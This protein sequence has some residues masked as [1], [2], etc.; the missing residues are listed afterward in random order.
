MK[1]LNNPS[2]AT[3]HEN[4]HEEKINL[5]EI[6]EKYLRHWKWFI[7]SVVVSLTLA[8]IFLQYATATYQSKAL[9]LIKEDKDAK[10][11]MDFSV[12][13]DLGLSENK[14]NL[15]NEIAII[16][17]RGLIETVS[18]KLELNK[19]IRGSQDDYQKHELYKNAPIRIES[20]DSDSLLEEKYSFE[21]RVLDEQH[22]ELDG[23][24]L[25]PEKTAFGEV[26]KTS[27]GPL[28]V[29]KTAFFS[30]KWLGEVL[31]I[32]L[33]PM[34]SVVSKLQKELGV[35]A[36]NKDADVL[37][38]KLTGPVIEKTNHIINELI[39]QYNEDAIEDKNEIARN[40]S[41]F[42]N[43]RMKVITV[44]LS[45]VEE[46]GESF[47]SKHQLV[48][49]TSDAAMYLTKESEVEKAITEATIQLRLANYM[50]DYILEHPGT[51][52]LLPANLGFENE[53]VA[54]M[55]EEYNK[56]VL[57]R[58]RILQSSGEKNPVILR[59]D[60]Q[61]EGMKQSLV[62]SLKNAEHTLE[63]NLKT[64]RGQE[65]IYKSQIASIPEYERE[66]R[67]ILRQQQIKETLYIYL[68]QKREENEIALASTV[69]NAKVIDFAYSNGIPVFPRKSIILVIALFV[70]L[71]IPIAVIYVRDLLDY[72]VHSIEDLQDL[73][74]P[75]VGEIPFATEK[76]GPI[77]SR[78]NNSVI[79]EAFRLVRTNI[80]FMLDRKK[81]ESKIIFITSG[82]SGE[83]KTF[84]SLNLGNIFANTGK[85]TVVIGLD[86]RAPKIQQY[87]NYPSH[88][89]VSNFIV[90]EELSI[91]DLIIRD[92]K[93]ENLD[94]IFS[95]DV[96]P[97]PSELLMRDRLNEL[98]TGLRTRYDY[99]IVDTAP[100]GLVA[101]TLHTGVYAD[102][103]LYVIRANY[104]DKRMLT[105]P[106]DLYHSG[107]LP[108][109]AVVL[110][111]V[112][113][114]ARSYGYGYGY[115]AEAVASK[116]GLFRKVKK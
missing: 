1:D 26:V 76:N 67:S 91:D 113:L 71:L 66:Y 64:L 11:L 72:K 58:N 10:S 102:L 41:D 74:L 95:G 59:L 22:F 62:E 86:L 63:L 92:E 4:E 105:L 88:A 16:K 70:A 2:T 57:N 110:N 96:P 80:N 21:I 6:I 79:S 112:N 98:F 100:V 45:D 25:K 32:D 51:E 69:S 106:R 93:S 47:K 14:R 40:T 38:V 49:V 53:A 31:E 107:K 46:A 44:E 114:K 77:I 61:L 84:T 39:R 55:T 116:R 56:A 68:L 18:Q 109:M 13:E 34:E 97:N 27:F 37:S 8:F 24:G 30:K 85:K 89:G 81:G 75:A 87:L 7:V 104:L 90:N 108:N 99:I 35:E 36:I 103:I 60:G 115:G 5:K 82:I 33:F 101:D 54:M 73:N 12:F 48:D 78:K 23:D 15:E 50:N 52:D 65:D 19:V 43:E 94:F 29:Y 42:I 17:S 111:G 28:T 9:I 3:Y 20:P 83:G